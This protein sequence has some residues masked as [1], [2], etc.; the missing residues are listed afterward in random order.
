MAGPVNRLKDSLARYG[1][2]GATGAAGL[3]LLGQ[4]RATLAELPVEQIEPDP[5]QPRRDLGD[6]TELK[7]SIAEVGI[8]QPLIVTVAGEDRFRLVAGERRFTAARELGLPTVPA[9]VRT[10]DENRRL[11]IQ[12][13]ENLHRKDLDALE[14]AEG[15]RRL[16]EEFGLT[17]EEVARRVGKSQPAVNQT[18][19]VLSLPEAVKREYKTSYTAAAGAE[20]S[21]RPV[22]KSVLLEIARRE[23]TD[24]QL[25][26]WERAKSGGLTVKDARQ[27]R[28]PSK[29]PTPEGGRGTAASAPLT[30][31]VVT[32]GA[33]VTVAM[34]RPGATLRDAAAELRRAAR[35]LQAEADA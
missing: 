19:R 33:T 13:I 25:A 26:L 10:V 8:I 7:A 3:G 17:Q 34:N 24:E 28:A 5:D 11:V 20:A 21:G 14:E 1:A 4:D 9:V 27:A 18:L 23:S 32:P 35:Q 30:R 31:R 22:S 29:A 16:M 2:T 15:Y 12:I 6:L